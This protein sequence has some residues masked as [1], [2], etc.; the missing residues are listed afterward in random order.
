M[1]ETKMNTPDFMPV[2]SVGWHESPKDGACIMEYVS[3]LAGEEW[4]D[5]PSCT[6]PVLALTAQRVNDTLSAADRH[7]LLPLLPRLMGTSKGSDDPV[8]SVRLG[9]W[10]A[11]QVAHLNN[12]PRVSAAI[13]A[14]ETWCDEPSVCNTKAASKAASAATRAAIDATRT[15]SDAAAA[16]ARA[17]SDA[18]AASA[19]AA[20]NA[21]AASATD[22]LQVIRATRAAIG[23]TRTAYGTT[24]SSLV[25]LLEGLITEYDR[26]TGRTTHPEVTAEDLARCAELVEPSASAL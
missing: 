10:A 18:A 3:F 11:R 9:L 5:R 14:A 13:D 22:D 6:H 24:A 1:S 8:L 26:L 19:R 12:D 4:S 23:A 17:A 20:S 25:G 15:A 16:S 2:L 21:A 7:L